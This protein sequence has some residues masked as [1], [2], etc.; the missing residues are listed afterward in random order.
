MSIISNKTFDNSTLPARNQA[1]KTAMAMYQTKFD[2]CVK[3]GNLE[4]A[5]YWLKR[6]GTLSGKVK[7]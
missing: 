3:S 6:L 7:G 1:V 5:D 2:A 4:K